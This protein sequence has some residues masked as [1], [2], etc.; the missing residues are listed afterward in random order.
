MNHLEHEVS[1]EV[2]RT[3]E[4][5][6]KVRTF[7]YE[8]MQLARQVLAE[9]ET[10]TQAVIDFES[11]PYQEDAWNALWQAR[12]DGIDKGL[13]RLA[14]GLGKT[15]VAVFDYAKFRSEQQDLG[16]TSRGLFVVHQNNILSQAADQF[17]AIIPEATKSRYTNA[18]DTLP[19]TELTFATF[20]TLREGA[21]KFPPRFFDYIIYDEAHHIEADTYKKVVDYFQPQFQLGLTATP[22]RVDR[23]D[24]TEHFGEP[25]YSKTLAEAIKEGYLAE[26][27]YNIVFDEAVKQAL[28]DG[29][30]PRNRAEI[31]ALFEVQSRNEKIV[32]TIQQ[33]QQDI[34]G[35]EGLS[36]VKTIVFCDS[37]NSSNTFAELLNGRSYNSDM[38]SHEQSHVFRDF[39]NGILET[40][41]V[42]DMFNEGVDVPDARLMIFLRTTASKTI[43][44]QQLGRGLR[45]SAKKHKITVLD[46]VANIDRLIMLDE[47]SEIIFNQ[48]I[49]GEFDEES[50]TDEKIEL[51]DTH[52]KFIFDKEVVDFIHMYKQ[53]LEK[54][55]LV[56][57]SKISNQEIIAKALDISP[58]APLNVVTIA[59]LSRQDFPGASTIQ[60][61]FGSIPEFQRACGFDVIDWDGRANE[62]IVTLARV[63]SPDAPLS[64][65]AIKM[66]DS[67]QFPSAHFIRKRFG[68][69]LAFQNACG[70]DVVDWSAVSNDELVMIANALSPDQPLTKSALEQIDRNT[71]PSSGMIADRFGSL[72]KFHEACGHKAYMRWDQYHNQDFI[73]LALKI[74]PN[75][76]LTLSE[77]SALSREEFPDSGVIYNRFGSMIEFH[78]AC[79]FT[80]K[81]QWGKMSDEEI[82]VLA[83]S[84]SPDQPMTQKDVESFDNT[85]FPS[86]AFIQKRFKSTQAFQEAA[87]FTDVKTWRNT[88]NDEII[89]IAKSISPD[90]PLSQ[91]QIIDLPR[92][93]FPSPSLIYARFG[94]MIAFQKACGFEPLKKM[95]WEQYTKEDLV[96]LAKALSPDAPLSIKQVKATSRDEF[97]STTTVISRFGTWKAFTEACGF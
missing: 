8:E 84:L 90:S 76:P 10:H 54:E 11:R 7:I 58:D 4:Q 69:L 49:S 87:G 5:R 97:P 94:S 45:K 65:E 30:Q 66:L 1:Q 86:W 53:L 28:K 34:K 41:T 2:T 85:I 16:Q 74:S 12:E 91:Q 25:L 38:P 13:I 14:T 68:S 88:T 47:L 23:R 63:I 75:K 3:I 29:F 80:I 17:G 57:W 35:K 20:Q 6:A 60:K 24:I 72:I 52:N 51:N 89:E 48:D 71:L 36:E 40:I 43:F 37:I 22:H 95:L 61:R 96:K 15:Q 18:Q 31:K 32:E 81:P 59:N 26:V 77:I 44:E 78:R 79:G 55:S 33:A 50:A 21:S 39:T 83:R 67:R 42:R 9:H 92:S 70:F 93:V 46:C 64:I 27:D 62:E 19:D 82:G 73:D 56:N